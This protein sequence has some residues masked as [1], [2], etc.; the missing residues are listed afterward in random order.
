MLNI[1]KMNFRICG[2]TAGRNLQQNPQTLLPKVWSGIMPSM[3][4]RGT[5]NEGIH[6]KWEDSNVYS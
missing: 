3:T 4:D 5:G 6:N 1:N 2:F